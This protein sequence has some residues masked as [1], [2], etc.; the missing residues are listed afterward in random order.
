MRTDRRV[1]AVILVLVIVIAAIAIIELALPS[2]PNVTL[3]GTQTSAQSATQTSTA[4]ASSSQFSGASPVQHVIIILMEN[5]EYSSVIGSSSAPYENMVAS[6]YAVAGAYFAVS[7]PSL[8]DYLAL[9]AGSTFGVTSD[10]LPAQCTLN[11]S[12]IVTLLQSHGLTWKEYA[13]SMPTNCS[14]SVSADGL[15]QPKHDPFVYFTGI[16]GTSGTGQTSA[17][18]DSHVVPLSQ[19]W[20]D[21]G[22]NALPNYAFITPNNCDDAHSCPLSTGDQWLSSVVPR[23]INSSSF[24][25]TALFITYDEGSTNSGFGSNAGG[26]VTCILVSPFAKQG[27]TSDVQYSHYSLLATVEA[28]F[29]LGSLGRND[30]GATPMTDIFSQQVVPLGLGA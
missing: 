10:C 30:A 7:H 9:I 20:T 4:T 25:S 18:C 16:T 13:E 15:Y 23:I 29:K 6:H 27:Y 19:F 24:S 12:S 28:I 1:T 14:Q 22:E 8:P 17:Y 3:T 21:L 11:S 2:G 26:Q 5:E